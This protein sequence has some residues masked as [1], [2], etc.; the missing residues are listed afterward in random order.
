MIIEHQATY[1]V[2]R[3]AEQHAV[4]DDILSR[5]HDWQTHARHVTG[6]KKRALVV[7]DF[8]VSRQYDDV[9][10]A[11]DDELE[12]STMQAVDHQVSEMV[13]P[14]KAAIYQ[15]ARN[16]CLGLAV[17]TSARLPQD[18]DE[19][20]AVLKVARKLLMARLVSAGVM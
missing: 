17:W 1:A 18:R 6:F 20:M 2:K 5:W 16:L 7:G 4:L 15:D 14:Y 3:D 12:H 10:G 11:L 19:R 13:D 9:N 8:R